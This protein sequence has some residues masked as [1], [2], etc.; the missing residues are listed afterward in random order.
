MIYAV[1]DTNVWVSALLTQNHEA[2]TYRVF[3]L[4]FDRAITPLYSDEILAEYEEVLSRKKFS[5]TYEKVN[6]VLSFV[7]EYG[8]D[9]ERTP[10]LD[11]MPDEDDRV[12]YEVSLSQEDSFLVTGNLK[13]YPLKPHVVTP[14]EF[15]K[16][17]ESRIGHQ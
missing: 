12:F 11:S 13:H 4:V 10:F 9:T 2:A 3:S 17:I 16:I 14:A 7:R 1:I 5:F 6:R 8:I 15:M